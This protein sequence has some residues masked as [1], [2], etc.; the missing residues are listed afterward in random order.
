MILIER[1]NT[2]T[3]LVNN[4]KKQFENNIKQYRNN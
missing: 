1:I 2:N 3:K 4:L